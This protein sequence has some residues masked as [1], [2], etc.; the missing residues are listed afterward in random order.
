MPDKLRKEIIAI[1]KQLTRHGLDAGPDTISFHLEKDGHR[2]PSTSTIRR[3]LNTEGLITPA[4]KKKPKSSFVRFEA[5]MPNE[6]WQADIT[7]IYLADNT[8]VDV[9]DF[10]DD[11]SRYLLSITAR[12]GFSGPQGPDPHVVDT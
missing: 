11:H 7:Y 3:I 1:R 6:C 10:L 8:R 4:P 12:A 2:S 5:A 9:L